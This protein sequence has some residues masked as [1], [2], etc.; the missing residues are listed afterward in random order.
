MNLAKVR[1]A[2]K[3]SVNA[4]VKKQ[5]VPHYPIV[6]ELTILFRTRLPPTSMKKLL[7]LV[8]F[9]LLLFAACT[10]KDNSNQVLPY[11]VDGVSDLHYYRQ[12][13]G[14][15]SM[16]TMGLKVTY[17]NG[18]QERVSLSIEG[19]PRGLKDTI[20]NRVGIPTFEAYV[21]FIDSAAPDGIHPLKLVATGEY[22]GR[23]EYKFNFEVASAPD[24]GYPLVDTDYTAS[25]T[26]SGFN[27]YRV[28]IAHSPG[29][30]NRILF[31]NL[32]QNSDPIY[33]DLDCQNHVIY[34]PI[35]N[36]NGVNYSGSGSF[37]M[38]SPPFNA[39]QLNLLRDG[40]LCSISMS[41]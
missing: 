23:R 11:H 40:I 4:P 18:I 7:L 9:L 41:N 6:P 34:I 27:P 25:N 31:F 26:C 1:N 35:Q 2:L 10:K 30:K 37:G 28:A 21:E 19:L 17:E 38:F 29:V 14:M 33:A 16:P 8:N 15:G 36:V 5:V 20:F 24:C 22:S 32:D 12:F 13:P 3:W 39:I